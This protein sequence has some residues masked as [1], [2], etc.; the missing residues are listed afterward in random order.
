MAPNNAGNSYLGANFCPIRPTELLPLR[1]LRQLLR[2]APRPT[3]ENRRW[4]L[5][6][7]LCL[8]RRAPAALRRSRPLRGQGQLDTMLEPSRIRGSLPGSR[9]DARSPVLFS[10]V[11]GKLPRTLCMSITNLQP[12]APQPMLPPTAPSPLHY[13]LRKPPHTAG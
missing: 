10:V 5:V 2:P 12:R 7:Q 6:A 13:P 3:V 9:K 8:H 11:R 1:R 4:R